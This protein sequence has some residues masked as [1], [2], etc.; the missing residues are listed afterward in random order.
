ML[1]CQRCF[2]SS[3]VVVTVT[4]RMILQEELAS[5]WSV[6]VERHW[7]G[8]VEL[9]TIN[10]GQHAPTFYSGSVASEFAPRAIDWLLAHPKP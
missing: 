7:G 9:W 6:T 10:G 4:H 1:T 5:E 3:K 2:D 8:A